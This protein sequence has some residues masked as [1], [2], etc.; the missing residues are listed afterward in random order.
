MIKSFFEKI[1]YYLDE[2]NSW[3]INV[4][5]LRDIVQDARKTCTPRAIVLINPGNPTGI[6]NFVIF[7]YYRNFYKYCTSPVIFHCIGQCFTRK[8]VEDIIRF[9]SKEGLIIIA[10]EVSVYP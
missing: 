9:C 1:K 6:V 3:A 5:E 8:N 10:D 7:N 4:D 2:D